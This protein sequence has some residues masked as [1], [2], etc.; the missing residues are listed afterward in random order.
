MEKEI[1]YTVS[2]TEALKIYNGKVSRSIYTNWVRNREYGL[3]GIKIKG[4]WY[5]DKKTVIEAKKLYDNLFI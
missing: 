3:D 5:M 4:I 1:N 2:I